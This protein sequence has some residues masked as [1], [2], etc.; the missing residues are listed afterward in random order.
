MIQLFI[1]DIMIIIK[2]KKGVK[3]KLFSLIAIVFAVL[4]SSGCHSAQGYQ[5]TIPDL[6]NLSNSTSP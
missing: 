1:I 3:M 6:S 5:K 4:L 2:N